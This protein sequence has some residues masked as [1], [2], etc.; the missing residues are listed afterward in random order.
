[1]ERI[2]DQDARLREIYTEY[3]IIDA[4]VHPPTQL[5]KTDYSLF[6]QHMTGEQFVTE[7][8]RAG[9]RQCC[10]SV[11]RELQEPTDF[12]VIHELNTAAL[13]FRKAWPDFYIPGIAVHPAF[14]EESCAEIE[15]MYRDHGVRFVGELVPYAM[16]W[17]GIDLPAMD[18]VWDLICQK[19]MAVNVHL[20]KLEEAAAVLKKFPKLKFIIAH[21]T[22]SHGEYLARIDLF[23]QYENAALDISG[24]GPNS[25][26]MLRYAIDRAGIGKLLFGS[27]FPIRNPGMYIAGVLFEH[28]TGTE[29]EAVFSRNFKNLI[30]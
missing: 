30:G 9:I 29:R 14:P 12:S 24:S 15:T 1:M 25:W 22:S 6:K 11:I 18:P 13:D 17:G 19:E 4:H 2:L 16:S 8:R 28:L 5:P 27:D 20:W 21:P 10:G 23:A 7:L 26:G 3:E